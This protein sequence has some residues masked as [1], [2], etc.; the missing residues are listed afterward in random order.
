M[1]NHLMPPF[2]NVCPYYMEGS[3]GNTEVATSNYKKIGRKIPEKK[4]MRVG[5]L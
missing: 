4:K 3:T 5:P 1:Q 2:F